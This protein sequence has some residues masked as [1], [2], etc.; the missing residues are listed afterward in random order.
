MAGSS[1]MDGKGGLVVNRD[2]AALPAGR[3][4]ERA[5]SGEAGT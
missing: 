3:A 2:G 4:R 5:H 1:V